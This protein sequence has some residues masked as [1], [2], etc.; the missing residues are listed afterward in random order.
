MRFCD[1]SVTKV[2]L[3]LQ[4]RFSKTVSFVLARSML[5]GRLQV[6]NQRLNDSEYV[7]TAFPAFHVSGESTGRKVLDICLGLAWES[8]TGILVC[9]SALRL[10]QLFKF[11]LQRAL[12]WG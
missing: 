6:R 7:N 2:L 3:A 5:P 11:S 12:G 1:S 8:H 4:K 9:V 10:S